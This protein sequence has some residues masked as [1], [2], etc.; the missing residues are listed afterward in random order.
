MLFH[1]WRHQ[2]L[3]QN[4]WITQ[5]LSCR[6]KKRFPCHSM[7]RGGAGGILF[8]CFM[9]VIIHT[10][11]LIELRCKN[12]FFIHCGEP[13]TQR[14]WFLDEKRDGLVDENR[15]S[16]EQKEKQQKVYTPKKTFCRSNLFQ[17]INNQLIYTC[18][19]PEYRFN[20]ERV[21]FFLKLKC[22]SF[23]TKSLQFVR[24]FEKSDHVL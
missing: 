7:G 10:Q 13:K 2:R 16:N 12:T 20:I 4:Y 23:M 22:V 1:L 8:Y 19:S 5:I 9:L 24:R 18:L 17:T 21:G 14:K 6:K 11:S 15:I 3:E